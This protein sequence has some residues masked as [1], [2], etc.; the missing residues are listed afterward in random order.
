MKKKKNQKQTH[1][2]KKQTRG[3]Q[4]GGAAKEVKGIKRCTLPAIK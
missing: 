1:R 2:Y 4:G 3:Y